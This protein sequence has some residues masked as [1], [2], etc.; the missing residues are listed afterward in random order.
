[1]TIDPIRIIEAEETGRTPDGLPP[2]ASD[3]FLTDPQ[4]GACLVNGPLSLSHVVDLTFGPGGEGLRQ[5][6]DR[7]T[8]QLRQN[9]Q[10][11]RDEYA[12]NPNELDNRYPLLQFD[13]LRPMRGIYYALARYT[14]T[15]TF[16]LNDNHARDLFHSVA[17]VH[18]ADMVTLDAHWAGQV[19]KLKLPANFVRTYSESELDQFLADLDSAPP[20]R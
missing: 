19:R 17:S 15:D 6:T 20:T 14:I 13:A 2:C 5:V 7:K 11:W 12:R 3:E 8:A 4:F 18:C 10:E 1:M 16:R 9:I